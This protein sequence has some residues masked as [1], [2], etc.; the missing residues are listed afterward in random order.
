MEIKIQE[1]LESYKDADDEMGLRA[2]IETLYFA[3]LINV[4]EYRQWVL[5]AYEMGL[6]SVKKLVPQYIKDEMAA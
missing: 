6:A 3:D 5:V 1:W 4:D 2:V